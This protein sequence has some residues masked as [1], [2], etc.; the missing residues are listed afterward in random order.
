VPNAE[1]AWMMLRYAVAAQSP[2]ALTVIDTSLPGQDGWSLA[3]QIR[4][5]ADLANCPIILLVPAGDVHVKRRADESLPNTWYFT[6]PAKVSELTSA[7]QEALGM[8]TGEEQ[9]GADEAACEAPP[10]RIL[11]ADDAPVNREVATGLL[12][13]AGH[14]VETANNGREAVELL[15]RE[16]FDVVLMDL[17]MPE[18]DGMTATRAIR[19]QEQAT[20]KRTPIIAMTAHAT[21]D[22]RDQCI[23]AGMDGYLTKP[24]QP[25]EVF[26]ALAAIYRGQTLFAACD[27]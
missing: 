19:D 3:E 25:A 8:E 26:K 22:V 10:M 23:N 4:G 11:L 9:R 17:E 16:E 7:I 12:E 6:K 5:D 14:R 24:I 21:T 2:F 1:I 27:G 18:M 13:M 15:D 20:G